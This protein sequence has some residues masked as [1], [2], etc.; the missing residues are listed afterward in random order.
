MN[1]MA[2]IE[3]ATAAA[4]MESLS[5]LARRLGAQL[6]GQDQAF[7]RVV[8]DTRALRP[9][10]L[11]V[12][13][14]GERFDG[15]AFVARAAALGAAGCLVAHA[16]DGAGAQI[17]AG[18]TLQALQNYAASWRAD[19][20]LPVIGVT[21]SSGKTTT[22]QLL[23]AVLA[24]R[25]AVLATEGNLNNHIGVPLT[26]LRLRAE[27]RSAVI[28]M[29]AN[30]KGEIAQLAALARPNIGIVTQAGD[31]HLEGFGSREGV[32]R[33]KGELFAALDGGVAIVNADDAYAS[34]W[35]TLARRA[36]LLRFGFSAQAEVSADAIEL[37]AERSQFRLLTPSGAAEVVLPLPGRHNI[38]NALA[39]AA[40]G[41][42][43]NLTPAQIAAGLAQ[44]RPAAGRLAL[45]TTR[46]GA[47][48]LDD[49][50]NANP[51][52]LR[53]ALELLATLPG[54]RWL[55]LGDMKE[56]GP[57]A[58][59]LHEAAGREARALGIDRLYAL[60]P[61]A[62]HAAAGFG[63]GHSFDTLDAL[64]AA[65]RAELSAEVAVLVKGSR[66]SRMERVV[67][68]LCG[69]AMEGSDEAAH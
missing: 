66:S 49:S 65:L 51:T 40:A 10:E 33:A 47:R 23:A 42:A 43:L 17:V 16:V 45:K 64:L 69:P 46:E 57:E 52:S 3:T 62:Q 35:E 53:A 56:L 36:S 67:A 22:K 19:F 58:A 24:A 21:G 6:L 1:A 61:L 30:H 39:A 54:Q 12:A 34:L 28:E 18:D 11:F 59:A 9:G 4:P 60:G 48:L 25:G 26:L 44:A 38:A 14:V 55:V 63:S 37:H 27:H 15:H 29:G 5:V 8:T 68:A 13:L 32:A 50:Y 31:A 41:I 7:T 2:R 20:E